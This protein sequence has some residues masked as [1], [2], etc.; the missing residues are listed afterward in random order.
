MSYLLSD[1]AMSPQE[2]KTALS[3]GLLS[4]PLTDVDG[5]LRFNPRATPRASNG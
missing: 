4:F 2:L 3:S 5:E 1:T